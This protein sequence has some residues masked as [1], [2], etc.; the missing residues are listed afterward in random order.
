MKSE[1]T[2]DQIRNKGQAKKNLQYKNKLQERTLGYGRWIPRLLSVYV[3]WVLLKIF[4][5]IKPNS[6]SFMMMSVCVAGQVLLWKGFYAAG[7]LL[8]YLSIILDKVDGE[9]AR[10]KDE[11][12]WTGNFL[13][14]QFHFIFWLSFIAIG[15]GLYVREN[16]SAALTIGMV[17]ML[18]NIYIRYTRSS[19]EKLMF[20]MN[21]EIR[22]IR[23]IKFLH[24]D[25][26]I[27]Q[28]LFALLCILGR[29]DIFTILL[30]LAAFL[31]NTMIFLYFY[32]LISGLTSVFVFFGN[33]GEKNI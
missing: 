32:L 1:F 5:G 13:D 4:P 6:V 9:V 22:D 33:L 28:K 16:N 11:F 24:F 29:E 27:L 31:S 20:K 17:N 12:T 21:P 30:F 25:S 18:L 10:L 2:I 26:I 15:W 19:K 14:S 7:A 23:K 8:L 3:T